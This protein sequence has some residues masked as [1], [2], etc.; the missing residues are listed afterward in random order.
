M[1]D[2]GR[3]KKDNARTGVHLPIGVR[4]L[5]DILNVV[6][7]LLSRTIRE[8]GQRHA[9]AA[10]YSQRC[11]QEDTHDHQLS[12]SLHV[13]DTRACKNE[14]CSIS[15]VQLLRSS[16]WTWQCFENVS[17]FVCLFAWNI[18]MCACNVH[19]LFTVGV[20][21]HFKWLTFVLWLGHE[22][23]CCTCL[24]WYSDVGMRYIVGDDWRDL[25][26]VIITEARKP[27]FYTE[28]F[29]YFFKLFVSL[30]AAV[31]Y[32]TKKQTYRIFPVVRQPFIS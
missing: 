9:K 26:D 1:R 15:I 2:T 27:G 30:S 8:T 20:V 24:L 5:L 16:V 32:G 21:P 6:T 14:H 17:V 7:M 25:F 3:P 12:I 31:W 29:R 18:I 28:T 11:W 23:L 10:P 13:S 19:S 4:F 22:P